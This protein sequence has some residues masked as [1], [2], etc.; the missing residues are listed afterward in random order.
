MRWMVRMNGRMSPGSKT[1]QQL[2]RGSPK[3][4]MMSGATNRGRNKEKKMVR[5]A[6]F[7]EMVVF[8][9][10]PVIQS[11]LWY[12][13]E[14]T[15]ELLRQQILESRMALTVTEAQDDT[16]TEDTISFCVGLEKALSPTHARRVKN[17]QRQHANFIISNQDAYTPEALSRISMH[18]SRHSRMRAHKLAV[19]YFSYAR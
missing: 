2:N 4:W 5:F 19:N 3:I 7:S 14:D 15:S 16:I 13:S 10:H 12:S 8:E 6:G 11:K 9:V 18:N 1:N 17:H